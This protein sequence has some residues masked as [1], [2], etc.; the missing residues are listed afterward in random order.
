MTALDISA[1]PADSNGG[2]AI[3]S[4]DIQRDDG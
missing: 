2:C 3:V 4:F 1:F